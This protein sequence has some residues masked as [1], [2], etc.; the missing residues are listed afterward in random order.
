MVGIFE[1]NLI[2]ILAKKGHQNE[3]IKHEKVEIVVRE[4]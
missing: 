4:C 2:K 3:K 1:V